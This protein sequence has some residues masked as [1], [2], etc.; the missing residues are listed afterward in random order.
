M[1]PK[2]LKI[3]VLLTDPVQLLDLAPIDLFSM[4]TPEYLEICKIP[5]PIVS[6]AKPCKIYYIGKKASAASLENKKALQEV[7]ATS[8]ICLTHTTADDEVSPGNLD[9]LLLP[10]PDPNNEPDDEV[11][12][13]LQA[14]NKHKTTILVICTAAFVAGYSGIYDNRHVT[15]PRFLIPDLRKLFPKAEW[16]ESVRWKQD[17]HIW[18]AGM[19]SKRAFQVSPC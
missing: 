19:A 17:G 6:L 5:P 12:A 14:H 7:T 18:T 11:K 16:D 9:V 10:G 15:G 2:E 8:G 13:F 4:G 3:G 1:A